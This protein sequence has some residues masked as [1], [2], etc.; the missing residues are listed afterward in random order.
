MSLVAFTPTERKILEHGLPVKCKID[1]LKAS[2]AKHVK[3]PR[4][5]DRVYVDALIVL[6]ALNALAQYSGAL[7]NVGKPFHWRVPMSPNY[8]NQADG[9]YRVPYVAYPARCKD[10][11]DLIWNRLRRDLKLIVEI[12]NDT[13]QEETNLPVLVIEDIDENFYKL[14]WQRDMFQNTNVIYL[15][16]GI[17]N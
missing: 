5:W 1:S 3:D 6:K 14:G 8:L 10:Q 7:P 13:E 4:E 17:R 15:H 12:I 2:V 16:K 9:T 11:L